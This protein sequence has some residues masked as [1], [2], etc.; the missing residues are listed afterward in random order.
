[1]KIFLA[2]GETR[3]WIPMTLARLGGGEQGLVETV[4]GKPSY[5][6]EIQMGE[7]CNC[8]WQGSLHGGVGGG[9]TR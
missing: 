1:M 7:E 8:S 9:T 5:L 3:H 6:N 2:G 4:F